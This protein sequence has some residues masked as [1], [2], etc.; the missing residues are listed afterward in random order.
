VIAYGGLARR[1]TAS[2]E[3]VET[4]PDTASD[5]R[6]ELALGAGLPGY[7]YAIIHARYTETSGKINDRE[8]D[9]EGA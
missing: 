7:V 9:R 8:N 2:G 1:R 5:V 4:V 3:S 6:W